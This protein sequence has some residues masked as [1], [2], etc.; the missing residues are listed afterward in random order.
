MLPLFEEKNVGRDRCAFDFGWETRRRG[1]RSPC[2]RRVQG[3]RLCACI[4]VHVGQRCKGRPPESVNVFMCGDHRAD[5]K[6]VVSGERAT[7]RNVVHGRDAG[8]L[9]FSAQTH[10][11]SDRRQSL[12]TRCAGFWRH[13]RGAQRGCTEVR[14]GRMIDRQWFLY[15]I[16]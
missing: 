12:R 13:A 3:I 2:P 9:E 14:I 8:F 16:K 5:E 15:S 11:H 4:C 10:A 1:V 6:E 7:K